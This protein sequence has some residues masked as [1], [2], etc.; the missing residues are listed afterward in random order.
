MREPT[1]V[2]WTLP[3]SLGI[4]L[5]RHSPGGEQQDRGLGER[6]QVV[7]NV[8]GPSDNPRWTRARGARLES[9]LHGAPS[10]QVDRSDM[11]AAG[12]SK[13]GLQRLR[14]IAVGLRSH[15]HCCI[16]SLRCSQ[17]LPPDDRSVAVLLTFQAGALPCGCSSVCWRIAPTG[18]HDAWAVKLGGTCSARR[19][20]PRR[21]KRPPAMSLTFAGHER[22]T[23]PRTTATCYPWA[24]AAARVL[25]TVVPGQ[26]AW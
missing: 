22:C 17:P 16:R 12:D 20:T 13:T 8:E 2:A 26:P 6:S 1:S 25:A 10:C 18:A 24:Q 23:P 4:W 7:G 3:R 9:G 5:F 19:Q 14:S 21:R 15:G 11:K